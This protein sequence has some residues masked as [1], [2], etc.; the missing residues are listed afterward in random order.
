MPC[1][2]TNGR[3]I[4]HL[5]RSVWYRRTP[6]QSFFRCAWISSISPPSIHS[7]TT[8]PRQWLSGLYLNVLF[9]FHYMGQWYNLSCGRT[10][11]PTPGELSN[12]LLPLDLLF[13][14]TLVDFTLFTK[15][16]TAI[17]PHYPNESVLPGFG[18]QLAVLVKLGR[19][20]NLIILQSHDKL[21]KTDK[22][23]RGSKYIRNE[24]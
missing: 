16:V 13:L 17:S 21:Q 18:C 2:F 5:R 4:F 10:Q 15:G 20:K 22:K 12:F 3:L 6:F 24:P 7:L 19:C 11:N 8:P 14:Q 9:A 1:A 23:R